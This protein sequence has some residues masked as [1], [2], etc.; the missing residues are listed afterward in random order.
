MTVKQ[1]ALLFFILWLHISALDLVFIN[2]SGFVLLWD[3][4]IHWLTLA[5]HLFIALMTTAFFYLVSIISRNT[6]EVHS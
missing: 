6:Q 5:T 2:Y 3:Q 4:N 1:S